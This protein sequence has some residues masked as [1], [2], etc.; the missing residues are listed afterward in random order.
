[1]TKNNELKAPLKLAKTSKSFRRQMLSKGC[2]QGKPGNAPWGGGGNP[3]KNA[4]R[5]K[6]STK[7]KRGIPESKRRVAS[8]E[9]RKL[10]VEAGGFERES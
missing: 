3:T 5:R 4:T 6:S 1:M 10:A 7:K 8:K 2:W 9:R